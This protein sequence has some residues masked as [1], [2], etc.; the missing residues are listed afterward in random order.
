MSDFMYIYSYL[1]SQILWKNPE[2]KNLEL[3]LG[4]F[5]LDAKIGINLGFIRGKGAL[6]R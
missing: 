3:F 5:N 6:G 4:L 1:L 2:I